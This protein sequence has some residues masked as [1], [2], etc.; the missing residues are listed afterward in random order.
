MWEVLNVF[1]N[2]V[3]GCSA[4]N[5][6]AVI[7][8]FTCKADLQPK[9]M[10]TRQQNQMIAAKFHEFFDNSKWIFSLEVKLRSH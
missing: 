7:T 3:G 1:S 9:T 8:N 6:A 5:T 10:D 4:L 2:L